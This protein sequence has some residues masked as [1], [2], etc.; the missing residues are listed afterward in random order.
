MNDHRDAATA[1]RA[2]LDAAHRDGA[3]LAWSR[4]LVELTPADLLDALQHGWGLSYVVPRV[5]E[6][7]AADPLASAGTFPGDLLRGLMEVRTAFWSRYP[8]LYAQYRDALRAGA[9]A[10]RALPHEQ[11]LDF[12]LHTAR[13]P[14]HA[15]PADVPP[16]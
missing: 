3:G 9:V 5:L 7:V 13:A 14:L 11:R 15:P 1:E 12:W 8:R 16:P 6:H 10:R 4:K 2:E